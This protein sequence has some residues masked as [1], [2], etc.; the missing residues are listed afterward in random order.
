MSIRQDQYGL[1]VESTYG[2]G[3]D[4]RYVADLARLP[5]RIRLY[6]AGDGNQCG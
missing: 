3:I 4:P 1:N 6:R 2:G 5:C